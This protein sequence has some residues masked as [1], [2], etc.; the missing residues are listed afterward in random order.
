MFPSFFT[1]L[2]RNWTV[3]YSEHLFHDHKTESYLIVIKIKSKDEW[4]IITKKVM[5]SQI[6]FGFAITNSR[7]ILQFPNNAT[8]AE[9]EGAFTTL[10]YHK[11][12]ISYR[13]FVIL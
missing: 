5:D 13:I 8:V 1:A 3:H 2:H 6:F 12:N 10:L 7:C 11:I 9:E 4:H